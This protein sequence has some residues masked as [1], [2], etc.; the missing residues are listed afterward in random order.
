[1]PVP[2]VGLEIGPQ[3][4]NDLNASLTILDSHN[5]SAGNGVPI[6][7]SGLDI[8][9]D[10]SFNSNSATNL[11]ASVYAAV[12]SFATTLAIYVIGKDLYY[13]DGDGNVVRITQ[14]GAV[15]GA[16]GTITGLPSGTAGAAFSGGTFTF[17]SASLTGANID[18]ASFILRNNSA[19]SF[20]LTL[21]PP[22]AMGA[23]F[24]LTLPSLPAS[25]YFLTMDASGNFGNYASISGGLVGSNLANLTITAGKIANATITTTQISASA[26]ILGT[27][28]AAATVARSNQVA[29]GQ[30]IS[31]SSGAFSTASTSFVDVTNLSVSITT[32]GRPVVLLLQND[33]SGNAGSLVNSSGGAIVLQ[34]LQGVTSVALYSVA[35]NAQLSTV[36]LLDTPAAGTY[37]YKVQAH[38]VSLG[39]SVSVQVNRAKLV[40]YEL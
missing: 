13:T 7:P 30:Q 34:V 8:N 12:A 21:N 35:T 17:T 23:N 6:N 20:G 38:G 14:G 11:K 26:G 28:L 24:S 39:G 22:A 32:S 25:Q 4:A 40:A 36:Y 29:V 27:Q 15:T 5:H 2:A 31:S 3:W 16:S 37:T 19:S 10:F 33:A 1:M 9:T 18:G